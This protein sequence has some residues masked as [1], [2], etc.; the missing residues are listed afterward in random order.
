MIGNVSINM[1]SPEE[2]NKILESTK[3]GIYQGAG[4]GLLVVNAAVV[5][6]LVSKIVGCGTYTDLMG[7]DPA[8]VNPLTVSL[9]VGTAGICCGLLGGITGATNAIFKLKNQN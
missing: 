6:E 5:L 3:K 2:E 4:L 9:I 1:F 7:E 8:S